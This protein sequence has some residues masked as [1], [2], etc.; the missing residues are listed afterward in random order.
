M[1]LSYV[2]QVVVRSIY[3]AILAELVAHGYN[4]DERVYPNTPQGDA[5]YNSAVNALK[6]ANHYVELY[7]ESSRKSKDAKKAPSITISLEAAMLGDVGSSPSQLIETGEGAWVLGS[8]TGTTSTL[9][10]E[11][12][13]T[14]STSKDMYLLNNILHN[15]LGRR[16][17]I[18]VYNN[19]SELFLIEQMVQE[20]YVESDD[21]L[22][23]TRITY[24]VPDVL[25]GATEVIRTGIVPIGEIKVDIEDDFQDQLQVP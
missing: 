13:L 16:K 4:V 22:N 12:Y 7:S 14:S 3:Y 25:L 24:N 19:N 15:A 18:K 1:E 10:V 2:D 9:V 5:D 8:N 23:D 21:N 11:I 20:K 6:S 17:M